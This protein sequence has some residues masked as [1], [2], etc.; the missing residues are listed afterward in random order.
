VKST[1]EKLSPTRVRL[2]V[3]LTFDEL[4][5]NLDAAYKKLGQQIR[6]PGFRPG[7]VPARIIDQ[8]VGRAAV[9]EQV[10]NDVVPRSYVDAAREHDVRALGQPDIE[11]TKLE[12]NDSLSFTA[13]VDVRPEIEL[14]ALDNFTVT[15]DAP[16]VTD[17][18][19]DE[20]LDA[21]RDRFGTLVAAD[22]TVENGDFVSL[23]LRASIDGEEID[24]GSATNMS[25]EV[26]SGNLIEGL[27]EAL[28]G[29]AAGETVTFEAPLQQGD[30]AGEPATIEATVNSVKQKELPALDDEFAQLASE[31]DTIAELREDTRRRLGRVRQLEQAAQARDRLVEQLIETVQFPVP[32]SAVKAE[33]DFREHD[34]VH[35]LGHD[36]TLFERYLESQ[37]QSRDEFTADLRENAEK[38]VRAQF[39]LDAV[40]EQEN[41]QVGNEELTEYLVRQAAQWDMSPQDFA[42]Q[43][44][45][46]GNLPALVADV[47]RNKAL[48]QLLEQATVV[49]T[50]GNSVDLRTLMQ[51]EDS[52]AAEAASPEDGDDP[53]PDAADDP[54]PEA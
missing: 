48:A 41:V 25:Y 54:A 38:S 31:F 6:V 7:K 32:E 27:D 29:H 17:A 2:A 52:G 26:G 19:V 49:D 11:V 47:R 21:L 43:V 44:M 33:V 24:A 34:V 39:V 46:S 37:G 53:T 22:R 13:E 42:K 8:R 3:E 4:K 35:Q 5:P 23:D 9:L 16:T 1:A 45:D 18:D 14:P 50:S 30:R 40:A 36:D 15:V 51:D 28:I 20:Q 12:D 10:V